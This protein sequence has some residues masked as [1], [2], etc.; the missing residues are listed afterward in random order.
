MAPDQRCAF[1]ERAEESAQRER[2]ATE[3]HKLQD[4]KVSDRHRDNCLSW[5]CGV[6]EGV[7]VRSDRGVLSD[8]IRVLRGK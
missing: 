7:R 3:S 5:R 6:R 8:G 1:Q 2:C 4:V